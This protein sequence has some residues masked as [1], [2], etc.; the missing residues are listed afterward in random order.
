MCHLFAVVI[1]RVHLGVSLTAWQTE[2]VREIP[3]KSLSVWRSQLFSK[4]GFLC[5]NSVSFNKYFAA[6]FGDSG[7]Q[8]GYNIPEL[9]AATEIE[10]IMSEGWAEKLRSDPALPLGD[11]AKRLVSDAYMCFYQSPDVRMYR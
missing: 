7:E 4:A 6:E 9:T 11:Q 2:K 1:H 10:K 5:K 8:N 3:K